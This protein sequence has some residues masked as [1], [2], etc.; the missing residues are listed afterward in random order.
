M[1]RM[2]YFLKQQ[3]MKVGWSIDTCVYEEMPLEDD[4]DRSD[5]E[6]TIITSLDVPYISSRVGFS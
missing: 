3:M 1:E 6:R 5:N 4:D 2:K